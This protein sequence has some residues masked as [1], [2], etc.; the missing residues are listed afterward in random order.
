MSLH[1]KIR[2]IFSS[3]SLN[4]YKRE[5]V[6][7]KVNN[8]IN[9]KS[10]N[11][12]HLTG[13]PGS[14]KTSLAKYVCRNKKHMFI[15]AYNEN[16]KKLIL[17]NHKN[18]IWIIDE[19]DKVN[20]SKFII[21]YIKT[22]NKKLITLSNS[23]N[24]FKCLNEI[25]ISLRPYTSKEIEDILH[26]KCEEVGEKFLNEFEIKFIAKMFG[27]TGDM[28]LVFNFIRDNYDKTTQKIILNKS[29]EDNKDVEDVNIHHKIIKEI[30]FKNFDRRK[31]FSIYIEECEKLGIP[32]LFRN[33]F[34]SVY[35]IYS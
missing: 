20:D 21:N 33:D 13:N 9:S 1:K 18:K 17:L 26:L 5:D 15:N 30:V 24:N 25:N 23:L 27:R 29:T 7:E 31:A 11:I 14:G 6:I 34:Y 3:A 22:H 8:F 2:E 35:D 16:I 12:L 19:F 32:Y 4:F 10:D 28:R